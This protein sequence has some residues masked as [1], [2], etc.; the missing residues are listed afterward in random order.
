MSNR[1]A[2]TVLGPW[3]EVSR[4]DVQQATRTDYAKRCFLFEI[5]RSSFGSAHTMSDMIPR[6]DEHGDTDHVMYDMIC[7]MLTQTATTIE[8]R[9]TIAAVSNAVRV[10]HSNGYDHSGNKKTHR[11]WVVYYMTTNQLITEG[12]EPQDVIEKLIEDQ[13]PIK[14][15]G[16]PH[17]DAECISDS[18][19]KEDCPNYM[20]I[21]DKNRSLC[22]RNCKISWLN[23]IRSKHTLR[24]ILGRRF[25]IKNLGE[26]WFHMIFSI[27]NMIL[28]GI[29]QGV[30]EFDASYGNMLFRNEEENWTAL[31]MHT[32]EYSCVHELKSLKRLNPSIRHE[33]CFPYVL[34]FRKRVCLENARAKDAAAAASA[35][36]RE[37]SVDIEPTKEVG[38][39]DESES[40]GEESATRN[41]I[42]RFSHEEIAL[43]KISSYK[44]DPH[45]H[46]ELLKRNQSNFLVMDS[47]YPVVYMQLREENVDINKSISD[48][49][50]AGKFRIRALMDSLCVGSPLIS[51]QANAM[52][53][54]HERNALF[55]GENLCLRP[56]STTDI[57]GA[58]LSVLHRGF[59]TLGVRVSHRKTMLA[60]FACIDTHFHEYDALKFNMVLTGTAGVGKSF[61][62]DQILQPMFLLGDTFFERCS[63]SKYGAFHDKG[64]KGADCD[65]VQLYDDANLYEFTPRTDMR[66]SRGEEQHANTELLKSM[67]TSNK[68]SRKTSMFSKDTNR[69]EQ[70]TCEV[71]AM[72]TFILL[73]NSSIGAHATSAIWTRFH[74][75]ENGEEHRIDK[76]VSDNPRALADASEHYKA[77]IQR[78]CRITRGIHFVYFVAAKAISSHAIS[79]VNY[80]A[81]EIVYAKLFPSYRTG[82]SRENRAK[83]RY[84]RLCR[85]IT[86]Y[87]RIMQLWF[88]DNSNFN[89]MPFDPV[90]QF[91]VL[92]AC[93]VVSEQIA[94]F[95]FTLMRD[96]WISPI[97]DDVID[98]LYDTIVHPESTIGRDADERAA[99]RVSHP[100]TTATAFPEYQQTNGKRKR[101]GDEEDLVEMQWTNSRVHPTECHERLAS[102]VFR[103]MSSMAGF[104][105]I[106]YE[107]NAI[108]DVIMTL[109]KEGESKVGNWF[110]HTGQNQYGAVVL[111][112]NIRAFQC[113]SRANGNYIRSRHATFVN[114]C[115]GAAS[116]NH[117]DT[118]RPILLA[119]EAISLVQLKGENDKRL[120]H[121]NAISCVYH[122][123][124][125]TIRATQTEREIRLSARFPPTKTIREFA[126]DLKLEH[127]PGNAN[128][129]S[130]DTNITEYAQQQHLDKIGKPVEF[131]SKNG[132]LVGTWK[133]FPPS[134]KLERLNL[135]LNDIESDI[136]EF[137][138]K[139]GHQSCMF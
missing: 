132:C 102:I 26:Q 59:E 79:D 131:A 55:D 109:S 97:F 73:S 12:I 91:P 119:T 37:T 65:R 66:G 18:V 62:F 54:W 128:I 104:G 126:K 86:L 100:D 139:L 20:Y 32:S 77:L 137:R 2:T 136:D 10:F 23:L 39:D 130:I 76:H 45:D 49:M 98:A 78:Y 87:L 75:I 13:A 24:C 15:S 6:A 25:Y 1:L 71:D 123:H 56:N 85:S 89:N 38:S 7:S 40:G 48:P 30:G 127:A 27:K 101:A 124:L 134:A 121:A 4:E 92:E 50:E 31:Q 63:M 81:A 80:T 9:G 5:P 84:M 43:Q 28:H 68:L 16:R 112:F 117:A 72:N 106:Q 93:L 29:T 52:L 51:E 58:C 60:L 103:H 8:E 33:T 122:Q 105:S 133:D 14:P 96:E 94:L 67:L 113:V 34:Y 82:T 21:G 61:T 69:R 125:Q 19:I 83:T 64:S 44:I 129:K 107:I 35:L 70:N 46:Y 11:F 111:L 135:G 74:M 115:I 57:D 118:T 108:R 99:F 53:I 114:T 22:H 47:N 3:V 95:A 42:T 17:P 88:T 36:E 138:R 110:I 120:T 116:Y 90:R 41:T